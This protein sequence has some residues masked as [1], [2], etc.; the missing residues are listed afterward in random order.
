[1][2]ES[3]RNIEDWF[4][5]QPVT[6]FP[7]DENYVAKYVTI[8]DYMNNQVHSEIKAIVVK[9]IPDTYLNDHGEKHIKKVIEKASEVINIED[10]VLTPYEVFFLLLAIQIHDA[11]HIINGRTGHEENAKQIIQTFGKE[12][13]TSVE[14]KY[15]ALIAKTHS[16]KKDP[17]GNLPENQVVSNQIVNLKRIAA[18]LR[19]ADELADDATRASTFLLE[20]ERITEDSKIFHIFSSCLDSCVALTNTSKIKMNFYLSEDILTQKYKN[21]SGHQIF[22]LDEIY[23]RNIKTF[24]ECLYCNRFLPEKYRYNTIDIDIH[25]ETNKD[26]IR[27]NPVSFQLK[28]NGYPDVQNKSIFEICCNELRCSGQDINGDYFYNLIERSTKNE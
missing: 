27:P 6:V 26:T 1:M 8:R 24:L 22:L 16:G 25:I 28:E 5:S 20:N 23:K 21:E 19:L 3:N 7:K 2:K 4:I 10:D 11:G 14:K 12:S 15:I 9:L 13:L 18:I 17:I